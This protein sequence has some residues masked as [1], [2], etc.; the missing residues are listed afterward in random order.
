MIAHITQFSSTARDALTIAQQ[1][2]VRLLRT[3]SEPELSDGVTYSCSPFLGRGMHQSCVSW[4]CVGVL[5]LFSHTLWTAPADKTFAAL[6]TASTAPVISVPGMICIYVIVAAEREGEREYSSTGSSLKPS[7][8]H[9]PNIPNSSLREGCFEIREGG[10]WL[11]RSA[12]GL[13]S[14][15]V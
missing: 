4:Y 13:C 8:S 6:A 15:R 7:P 10:G 5:C 3:D 1:G 11:S 9:T 2:S 12:I 14:Y